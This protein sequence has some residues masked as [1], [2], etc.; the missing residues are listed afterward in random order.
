MRNLRHE[1]TLVICLKL[2]ALTLLWIL[3]FSHT[4]SKKES[5]LAMQFMHTHF[6]N[7]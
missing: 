5:S 7:K 1:I 4:T 3:F 2:C 6:A